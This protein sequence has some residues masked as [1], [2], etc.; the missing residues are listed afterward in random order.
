MPSRGDLRGQTGECYGA[1]CVYCRLPAISP[2][3]SLTL[4]PPGRAVVRKTRGPEIDNYDGSCI[5]AP[6]NASLALSSLRVRHEWP[7]RL[8][9]GWH[10][11]MRAAAST[12]VSTAAS[13]PRSAPLSSLHG[14]PGIR[15]WSASRYAT[16]SPTATGKPRLPRSHGGGG[17]AVR[18]D[19]SAHMHIPPTFTCPTTCLRD[20]GRSLCSGATP[21]PQPESVRGTLTIPAVFHAI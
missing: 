4:S 1:R 19:H 15:C 12:Q 10:S 14:Q 7:R 5:S 8:E 2:A 6:L 20:A 11:R 16:H 13:S 9:P 17:H 21:V 18:T 3:C